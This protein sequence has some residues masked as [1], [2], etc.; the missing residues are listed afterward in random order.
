MS[1]P[2]GRPEEPTAPP[3]G[4]VAGNSRSTAPRPRD[5]PAVQSRPS[6]SIASVGAVSSSE[7]SG[8]EP[9][10][11][12]IEAIETPERLAIHENIRRAKNAARDRTVDFALQCLFHRG[13][14]D[15]RA[16]SG[17]VGPCFRRDVGGDIGIGN[18]T[19]VEE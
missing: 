12:L 19:A 9:A 2:K 6:A 11:D 18:V 10:V 8:G 13:V 14:V 3:S 17:A 16:R 1:V 7:T 4:G 15:A 5:G